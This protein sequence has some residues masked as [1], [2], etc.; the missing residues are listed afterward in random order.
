VKPEFVGQPYL[1]HEF[2]QAIIAGR[3]PATTCQDNIKSLRIVFDTLEAMRD[4]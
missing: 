4:E 1:L 2:V 3:K